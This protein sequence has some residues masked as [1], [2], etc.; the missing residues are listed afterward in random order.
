M[1]GPHTDEWLDDLTQP[2]ADAWLAA[3]RRIHDSVPPEPQ[4]PAEH[5]CGPE[6]YCTGCPN[7][8]P[9]LAC[10]VWAPA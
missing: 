4:Q 10:P 6:G 2:E 1:N 5:Q 9:W 3:L 8:V 7:D